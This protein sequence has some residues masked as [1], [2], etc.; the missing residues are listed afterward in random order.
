MGDDG[1]SSLPGSGSFGDS[2]EAGFNN[3]APSFDDRFGYTGGSSSSSNS[4][5]FFD[6][7]ALLAPDGAFGLEALQD[8]P[9][10]EA[11][12][13]N[14]TSPDVDYNA[15]DWLK[16]NYKR[17]Q[18]YI[19]PIMGIAG[20]LNPSF[21]VA[22]GLMSL[23]SNPGGTAARQAGG[24]I[25]GA[26]GGSVAGPWGGALGSMF[27]ASK[28][29][30]MARDTEG[31]Y[32]MATGPTK[33]SSS[34][35]WGLLGGAFL[36]QRAAKDFGQQKAGLQSL[37]GQDSPYAQQLRQSLQRTDA[38]AGRRSQAGQREVEL[39][40]RLAD[41]NSRNA[42]QIQSLSKDQR[43]AQLSTLRD[44]AWLGNQAGWFGG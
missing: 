29:G 36:G 17:Y 30:Q 41:L 8:N 20:R 19:N 11:N 1:F 15:L 33:S 32:G 4:Q 27:G 28:A 31:T 3:P 24:A 43:M 21:A 34:P 44:L 10:T 38:A 18:N 40:A 6:P 7:E 37:Y 25:G 35:D 16:G 5:S 12:T 9:Y 14:Y 39:Q 22:N 23:Y 2:D 13:G 26:I 42:P